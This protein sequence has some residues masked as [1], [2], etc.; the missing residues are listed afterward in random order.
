MDFSQPAWLIGGLGF[1]LG[2]FF[3]FRSL[4]KNRQASL[5]KFV[6]QQLIG[7]LT[8]NI[9]TTR[10]HL[11]K[12][13][14]LVAVF[15]CFGALARPQVGSQWVDVKRKGIDLLFA[16][17][18]S[19]SMLA[20]DIKPNRL[21]RA[22][23]AIQDF[24]EKLNGDRVGLL[25][26]AGTAYLMCPLTIDYQ[27]FFNSLSA[28]N[29]DLIPLGGTNIAAV[30][31]KAVETLDNAANHKILIILTDGENLQGDAIQAAEAAAKKGLS[32]YTIGI[33][34]S[35]GELIPVKTGSG[36]GFVTDSAG[37]FVTS[38]LDAKTL[39]Q[40]AEKT[41]G[42]YAP[43][44]LAGEG[45]ATIYQK[46]LALIPKEDIAERRHKVPIER[47]EWPVALAVI[48]LMIE[49]LIGERKVAIRLPVLPSFKSLWHRLKLKRAAKVL[50][51]VLLLLAN[52][53][54][55]GY[56]SEGEDAYKRGDY[57]QSSQYY[58]KKLKG[59]PDDP[60]LLY[61]F[62]T[63][64]YKNNM[65]DDAIAAFSGALKS[66]QIDLQKK[67]YYNRGNS[68][69]QKGVEARQADPKA[70]AGHWQQALSSL[71]SALA[72][73]PAD[74]DAKNNQTIIAKQ[75]EEL[76]KQLK[77]DK[78]E[79][80]DKQDQQNDQ[81]KDQDHDKKDNSQQK[82]DESGNNPANQ[83]NQQD[84]QDPGQKSG[85]Q[86][87]PQT[88]EKKDKAAAD[89]AAKQPGKELPKE[90]Q[91]AP[92]DS[93]QAQENQKDK[94]AEQAASDAVRQKLGKMTTEEAEQLLNALKNEEGNL[95]F[96]PSGRRANE[97]EIDKDW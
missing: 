62:G 17:D 67:A 24:V 3:F 13:L 49:L 74:V 25:P 30:I 72:L 44:G 77:Q 80:Q 59:K 45:L 89:E 61:N 38:K 40:I 37:N 55:K 60:Q 1:C 34:T 75:L 12:L 92:A 31:D 85:Q 43:L 81:K 84:K 29:T 57:L 47:F 26:F 36:Q 76:E 41:G 90:A 69:Y 65:Y 83:E 53:H 11:K 93:G 8:G 33:G 86:A 7:R 51:L 10:R 18:T 4:A 91:T 35:K 82:K 97:K 20:E 50:G 54:G 63:A 46:K 16:L 66:D 28:V 64:A 70:T 6:A 96:V 27:A 9:S 88:G 79:N 48:L 94:A 73:D 15:L 68:Y 71:K 39:E 14:I 2:L 52:M 5:E 58:Q 32:I 42:L 22:S 95:N 21:Q 87:Q 78:Q 19:K 23:L 56:A